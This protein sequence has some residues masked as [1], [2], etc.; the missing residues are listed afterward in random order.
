MLVGKSPISVASG[1][2]VKVTV[3]LSARARA[4]LAEAG[5]LAVKTTLAVKAGNLSGALTSSSTLKR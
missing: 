5:R 4:R 2:A 3:P 1:A